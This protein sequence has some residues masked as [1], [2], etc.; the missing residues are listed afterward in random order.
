[1]MEARRKG[2]ASMMNAKNVK[3]DEVLGV[4]GI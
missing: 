3:R 1:M 4:F 2:G